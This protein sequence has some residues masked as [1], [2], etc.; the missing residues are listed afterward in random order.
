MKLTMGDI[1]NA[2][3]ACREAIS[4]VDSWRDS[5]RPAGDQGAAA[6]KSWSKKDQTDYD[7]YTQQLKRFRALKKKL[8][9]IERAA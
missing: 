1:G 8:L 3:E 4:A 6:R 9:A 5:T 2:I 7:D